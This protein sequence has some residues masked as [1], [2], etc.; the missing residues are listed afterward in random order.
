MNSLI[1]Q[2]RI[3]SHLL[4]DRIALSADLLEKWDLKPH[5]T[6]EVHLGNKMITAQV[7]LVKCSGTIIFFHPSVARK[8]TFP[9]MGSIR[10]QYHHQ[11]LRLGPVI[12]IL[13]T[14]FRKKPST[15]FGARTIFFQNF[16]LA[17]H[18]AKPFIYVFTPE[19]VNWQTRTVS[20]WY[21]KKNNT[22]QYQWVRLLSPLPDVIYERVPNRKAEA[23]ERVQTCLARFKNE[24]HI[25]VFNQGF[26]NKWTIYLLLKS[27]PKTRE[28]TP[29]TYL[30]PS[31]ETLQYMLDKY[32]MVYLKPSGGSL[33]M[34]I[35]RITY[36]PLQG[37]YCRFHQGE[38]NVLHRF[39]SLE[40]L[41]YYYF[42]KNKQRF[43]NYLVQQGIRLLK[44]GNRPLDFRVHMHKDSMG[45]WKIVGIAAKVAGSG[46]IT[47]HVR[48][49][50]SVF[51]DDLLDKA[52]PEKADHL[53]KSL[54]KAA[55]TIALS[56]EE[57]LNEPLGELGMDLG[58]DQELKVWL[59]EVNSKP[60]R[61]IFL[62]PSLR[63]AGRQSAKYITEYSLK[64][65]DFV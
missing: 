38:K 65:A 52:L 62:H 50:G 41:L 29:E 19:M 63:E 53:K 57:K 60:G 2:T 59:F 35:F 48:T 16:L 21:Y 37:Y 8:L 12:G 56:L 20:A 9:F 46:C 22:G 55:K 34:G 31:L 54:A 23:L 5:E 36:D 18:S 4:P 61:H 45:E 24:E 47:T 3:S 15:P 14:G 64:L 49:G 40:K 44:I 33:G 13:T 51:T 30:A 7:I 58:I 32:Q 10:A 42:R 11:K 26:F 39:Q 43:Q 17:S 25:P 28:Y 27:H 1:C 6:I